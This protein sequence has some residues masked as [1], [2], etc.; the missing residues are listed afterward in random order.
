MRVSFGV[1]S[2]AC[3]TLLAA[4][5]DDVRAKGLSWGRRGVG[6]TSVRDVRRVST[7]LGHDC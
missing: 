1:D 4:E 7:R 3:V 2:Q 5:G 6:V